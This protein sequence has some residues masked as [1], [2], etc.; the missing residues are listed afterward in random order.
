MTHDL[1]PLFGLAP[2][3]IPAATALLAF[4]SGSQKNKS[5]QTQTSTPVG[6]PAYGPLQQ[7]LLSSA[8]QRINSPSSLPAG[9]ETQGIGKIND[10]FATI[11]QGIGN[12]AAAQGVSGGPT[13]TYAR[14]ISDLNRGG[15]IAGFQ[16]N[17]PLLER[18]M[19]NEDLGFAANVLS[20]QRYGTSTTGT[21]TSGGGIGGGLGQAASILGYLY[22]QGGL[23]G[24]GTSGGAPAFPP[25]GGFSGGDPASWLADFMAG[26]R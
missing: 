7:A 12:R 25:G 19:R 24:G 16:T 10:T 9:Y 20:S 14:N 23:G 1:L 11:N 5:T 18:T 13:E 26:K 4:L 22:G 8:M 3:V 17:L 6:D 21:S 15:Q 2:L